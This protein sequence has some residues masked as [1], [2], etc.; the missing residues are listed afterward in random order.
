MYKCFG[1]RLISILGG[2]MTDSERRSEELSETDYLGNLMEEMCCVPGQPLFDMVDDAEHTR[3]K[4]RRKLCLIAVDYATEDRA[5]KDF[6]KDVSLNG[7]FIETYKLFPVGRDITI[8]F[9]SHHY[10]R[11]I[12][13]SGKIV[14]SVPQGIGVAF[15]NENK[16]LRSMMQHST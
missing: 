9:S 12:K 16:T 4:Y 14:R 11:P 8:T 5:F 10:S 13:I 6:I 15:E 3:R 2:S 7:V 1:L